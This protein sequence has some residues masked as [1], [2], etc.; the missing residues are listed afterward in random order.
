M[1]PSPPPRA[2]RSVPTW[3]VIFTRVRVRGVP[4]CPGGGQDV[5]GTRWQRW[6]PRLG[7]GTCGAAALLPSCLCPPDGASTWW[8]RSASPSLSL[9]CSVPIPSPPHPP[10][11]CPCPH[12]TLSPSYPHSCPCPHPVPVPS[13]PHFTPIAAPPSCPP[14]PHPHPTPVPVPVPFCP[15]P[16]P[17]LCPHPV[18]I[19][20]QL[21][22]LRPVPL[23]PPPPPLL[24]V[25]PSCPHYS[26]PSHPH[27]SP[28][29]PLPM[30]AA[31]LPY[32]K[33]STLG[34]AMMRRACALRTERLH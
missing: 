34:A 26:P 18:P 10:R 8:L 15:H 25:S 3:A 19:S 14:L 17:F 12:P 21:L 16:T 11:S 5:L 7:H 23:P 2:E 20:P 13:C 6:S 9:S 31:M 24:S 29:G 33:T 1:S 28:Y 27:Y 30:G 4:A 22:S 32:G